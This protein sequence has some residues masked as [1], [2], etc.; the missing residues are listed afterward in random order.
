LDVKRKNRL[1]EG[2]FRP[3][4]LWLR[5]AL[6]LNQQEMVNRLGCSFGA[7]RTWESGTAI[8]GGNWLA[9]LLQLA[10][11]T[12]DFNSF[13]DAVIS[14]TISPRSAEE[15]ILHRVRKEVAEATT[16][17]DGRIKRRIKSSA[18]SG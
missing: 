12:G 5:K 13:V 17:P 4:I 11:E 16:R 9:K 10:Q 8:P 3:A 7:Y 6:N 18:E 2:N 15:T 1:K 14:T